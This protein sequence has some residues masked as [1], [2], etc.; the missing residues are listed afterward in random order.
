MKHKAAILWKY[1]L[2]ANIKER[3]AAIKQFAIVERSWINGLVGCAGPL[4]P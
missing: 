3:K 1:I 4:W 2:F